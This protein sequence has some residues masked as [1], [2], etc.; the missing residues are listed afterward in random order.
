MAISRAVVLAVAA[1]TAGGA[2]FIA[3]NMTSVPPQVIHEEAGPQ[4]ALSEILVVQSDLPVGASIDGQ[5]AWQ[6]WPTDAVNASFIQKVVE[7]DAIET[8]TGS[9]ARA[10]LFRGEPMNKAKLISPG[11]N[12][13][14]ALLPSGK[15]AVA[16]GIETDSAAGG[17]ILPNDFVDIIMTRS[18]TTDGATRFLTE[19]VLSNVKV[20]AID[21]T[22]QEDASGNKTQI[23]NTAT[24][25]L[26]EEQARILTAARQMAASLTLALRS[27]SD[28]QEGVGPAAT[29]LVN[30]GGRGDTIRLIKNGE[31][32]E[33]GT[34]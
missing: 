26:D 21:Q 13:L 2:F 29:Y 16:L 17:F 32:S 7:P 25:E 6:Q 28:A 15:R 8:L 23:G 14:S 11:Q 19:I 30:G 18:E 3:R 20:L 10:P 5:L 34:N 22:I 31:M 9:T 1:V 24:L 4:I 33:V 12:V 27:I